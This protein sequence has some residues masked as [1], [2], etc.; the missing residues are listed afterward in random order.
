M[1]EAVPVTWSGRV[2]YALDCSRCY[3]TTLSASKLCYNAK[4]QSVNTGFQS[5]QFSLDLARLECSS[6]LLS[7]FSGKCFLCVNQCKTVLTFLYLH[8]IIRG[9]MILNWTLE[10][11][12]A[13]DKRLRCEANK[14]FSHFAHAHNSLVQCFIV[15]TSGATILVHVLS[16]IHI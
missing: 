1:H 8:Y 9:R 2:A 12:C 15:L 10:S 7:W 13:V 6:E 16:L 3:L 4:W 14:I 11:R 5:G